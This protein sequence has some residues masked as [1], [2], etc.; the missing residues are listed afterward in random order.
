[1]FDSKSTLFITSRFDRKQY[2]HMQS[3]L[4]FLS[5]RVVSYSSLRTMRNYIKYVTFNFFSHL[6]INLILVQC[7]WSRKNVLIESC[8]ARDAFPVHFSIQSMESSKITKGRK[9]K[10]HISSFRNISRFLFQISVRKIS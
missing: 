3:L 2:T 1:M 6:K 5:S 4:T 7:G 9:M 8:S 10:A